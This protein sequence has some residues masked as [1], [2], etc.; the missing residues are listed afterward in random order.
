MKI[1]FRHS[2]G[3]AL[4]TFGSSYPAFFI[5]HKN[6]SPLT[7]MSRYAWTICSN[8][9]AWT[10]RMLKCLAAVEANVWQQFALVSEAF[11]CF[12]PNTL[13]KTQTYI[14]IFKGVV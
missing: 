11:I 5:L 1:V 8:A 2:L 13:G 14:N 9:H 12:F 7:G 10:I 4:C 3:T 6:S